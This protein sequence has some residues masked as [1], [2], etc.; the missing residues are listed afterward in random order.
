MS[1]YGPGKIDNPIKP[2]PSEWMVIGRGIIESA[3]PLKKV[4]IVL[5]AIPCAIIM[6]IFEIF[7]QYQYTHGKE[8]MKKA[9]E[10]QAHWDKE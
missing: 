8:A 7:K 1:K 6:G 5:L 3:K 4:V 10:W 2:K 9:G